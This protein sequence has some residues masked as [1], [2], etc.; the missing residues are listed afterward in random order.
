MFKRKNKN[1]LWLSMAIF[2]QMIG[3]NKKIIQKDK[4]D[5]TIKVWNNIIEIQKETNYNKQCIYKCCKGIY[6]YHKGYKW[7][8]E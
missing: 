5:N 6:K 8:Y 4:N 2:K 1:R 3:S 7:Q